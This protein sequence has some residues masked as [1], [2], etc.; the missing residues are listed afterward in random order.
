MI[1]AEA[2]SLKLPVFMAIVMPRS[3][4]RV[5]GS[6]TFTLGLAVDGTGARGGPSRPRV[7]AAGKE[8]ETKAGLSDTEVDVNAICVAWTIK[9]PLLP[10]LPSPTDSSV[11]DSATSL[12]VFILFT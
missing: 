8:E 1:M 2:I 12:I 9:Y 3:K 10:V 7:G 11:V 5:A 4:L 6:N